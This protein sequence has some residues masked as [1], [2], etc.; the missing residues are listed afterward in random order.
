MDS[1]PISSLKSYKI[2]YLHADN[3]EVKEKEKYRRQSVY[4]NKNA[5]LIQMLL[6]QNIFLSK[7]FFLRA[8]KNPGGKL[9]LSL[10]QMRNEHRT[11]TPLLGLG[12]GCG[13]PFKVSLRLPPNSDK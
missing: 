9:K 7:I 4:L 13:T 10:P 3:L 2:D 8:Y 1:G 6:E 12:F 11:L 5:I